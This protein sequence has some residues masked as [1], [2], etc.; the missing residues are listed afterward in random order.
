MLHT[1]L[2][3]KLGLPIYS[4]SRSHW[5]R[6]LTLV[7]CLSLT[8]ISV[9]EFLHHW[10]SLGIVAGL[11]LVQ[12]GNACLPCSS[13]LVWADWLRLGL[14]VWQIL[15]Q[16]SKGYYVKTVGALVLFLLLCFG[17]GNWTQ[18]FVYD[19]RI[20][21]NWAPSSALS[22][23]PLNSFKH[24]TTLWWW[25]YSHFFPT[26]L[27]D[28]KFENWQ[29]KWLTCYPKTCNLRSQCLM[30]IPEQGDTSMYVEDSC[31]SFYVHKDDFIH[32]W[33]QR[34]LESLA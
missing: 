3:W 4:L 10:Q 5:L 14:G 8:G 18:D 16:G 25:W 2:L 17:T 34:L 33:P 31:K 12:R 11:R 30:N 15:L 26:P 1:S 27:K 22:S 32:L 21:Y 24:V 20:S 19:E 6:W 9:K 13:S 23:A 29:L 7:C 28:G